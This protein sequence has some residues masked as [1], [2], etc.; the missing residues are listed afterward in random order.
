MRSAKVCAL[1]VVALIVGSLLAADY[2][3]ARGGGRGGG[4]GGSTRGGGSRARS[5]RNARKD[6]GDR[7]DI[8]DAR[9]RL[10]QQDYR[11]H[12]AGRDRGN[13]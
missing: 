6:K 13:G 5:M 11:D 7:K 8:E 2:A 3:M 12:D 4:R 9:E 1:G 10:R